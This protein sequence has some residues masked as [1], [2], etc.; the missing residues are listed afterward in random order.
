MHVGLIEESEYPYPYPRAV[1]F[2]AYSCAI[3]TEI[4]GEDFDRISLK[5]TP[6][7]SLS[8]LGDNVSFLVVDAISAPEHRVGDDGCAYQIVDQ[9]RPTTYLPMGVENHVRW[10]FRINPGD[11]ILEIQS[12]E[13]IRELIAPFSDPEHTELIRHTVYKF[14]SLIA[15]R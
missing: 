9:E 4:L 11:D 1:M 3:L 13:R 6:G 12:P 5:R 15:H 2:D 10:E 7:G 14:N 8:Q